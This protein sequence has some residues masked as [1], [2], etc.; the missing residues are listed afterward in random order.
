MLAQIIFLNDCAELV[1]IEN[2]KLAQKELKKLKK[3]Y[4][5]KHSWVFKNYK[6]Y[7]QQYYWH[8]H[9]VKISKEK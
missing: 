7:E 2:N 3:E 8:I 1:I 9:Q 5:E 6:D 4:Y